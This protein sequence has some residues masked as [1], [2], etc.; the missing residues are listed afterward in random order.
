MLRRFGSVLVAGVAVVTVGSTLFNTIV[1][2]MFWGRP[3]C[4]SL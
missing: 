4:S 3:Y 1:A 2:T